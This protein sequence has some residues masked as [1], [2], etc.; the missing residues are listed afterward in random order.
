MGKFAFGKKI[1][2]IILKKKRG[3]NLPFKTTFWQTLQLR[4][5]HD[6]LYKK[7]VLS[8]HLVMMT[9]IKKVTD[10]LK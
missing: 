1:M 7:R 4:R 9:N 5:S 8:K 2:K 6:N 10:D 3:D